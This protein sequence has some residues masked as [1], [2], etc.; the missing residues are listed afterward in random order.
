M[1]KS[2]GAE[3]LRVSAP[4]FDFIDFKTF[5][6]PLG[7]WILWFVDFVDDSVLLCFIS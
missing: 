3:T 1:S 5:D 4:S 6:S 7:A 2:Q